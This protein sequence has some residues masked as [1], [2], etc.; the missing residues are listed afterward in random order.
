M[1]AFEDADSLIQH[2]DVELPKIKTAYEASLHAK[3]ISSTLLIEIKN[4]CENLRSA[5]DFAATGIFDRYGTSSTSKPKIY[6]PYATAA[7]TQAAFEKSGRIDTCIPGLSGSRPAIVRLLL[8][9]QHF[10]S[11]GYTWLPSFMELTNENK[12]QRLTPQVRKETKELRISGEGASMSLGEGTSIS[13]GQG[14]FIS[15]GGSI[16]P[17]GQSFDVNRPPQV[18][19][20]KA[21][22]ITWV[23]FHFETN[24]QPVIPFLENVLDGVRN[25]VTDL[26]SA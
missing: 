24:D 21:E 15:I 5:L 11:R 16:I 18:K 3:E 20:G 7:Q 2:A 10:G 19:G 4:F 6:F 25:I 23:S 1:G 8:E 12:H 26:S 22:V 14:A 17:G 9:M 13:I